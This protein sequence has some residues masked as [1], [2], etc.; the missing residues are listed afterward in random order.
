MRKPR[1]LLSCLLS[2]LLMHQAIAQ[3][4]TITGT[5]RDEQQKPLQGASVAPAGSTAGTTTNA[6]GNFS[7]S[8][9][10]SVTRLVIT[11]IGFTT[12]EVDISN[13][14]IV[15]ITLVP[16]TSESL[17]DVV[18][19]G[20]GTARRKDLTGSVSSISEKDLTRGA[21]T[22]PLQQIAGRA[23]G[24]NVNQIGS[25]PGSRPNVRIRGITSLSGGNDPL[26]VVDGVQGNLDLLNQVPPNEI[27]SVDILKD[28]SAT[29][30]YGSRGAP[31][32][33]IVT[34]KKSKTG[35]TA[36]EYN[37][38]ASADMLANKLD[39]LNA[40]EWG[41][42]ATEWGVPASAN[43]GANNDWYDLLTRTGYTQNHTVSFG[44]G[45]NS[46]SYRAS[47]NAI[48]QEG[49]VIKSGF[50]NYN[51][52]IQATQK[53]LDDKLTL[54]VNLNSGITN[55]LGSPGGLGR[56]AFRSNLITAAYISRPTDPIYNPNGTFF[57]DPDVFEYLN[58]YAVA[59]TMANEGKTNY[60]LTTLRGDLQ[61]LRGLTASWFGSWRK[62]DNN[63]GTYLPA[64][65][66]DANAIRQNGVANINN[67]RTDEKLMNTSL[68]YN[69]RKGD[70][71]LGLLAL[72]EW[73]KQDYQGNFTQAKGF[74][75]DLASFNA[76]QF[77][78][79]SRVTAGDMTSYRND[80]TTISFLGRVN[81]SYLDRYLVT[82]SIRRDGSSVLGD[83][84]K[85]GNFQSV[86]VAWNMAEEPFMKGQNIFNSL[87][88]KAG[89]GVTGNVQGL[90]P[91]NS[92][93]LVG[94][95][96]TVYFGGSQITNFIISQN[97]NPDLTWETKKMTNLG[98]EFSMLQGRI[99]GTIEAYTSETSNLLFNYTVPQPPYPFNSVFANV[100]KL[101]NDGID[102]SLSY[103][104]IESADLSL[105]LA[106]N[107]S[108]MKNKVLELSGS[109]KG[110]PLITDYVGWGNN[111]YLIKGEPIGVFNIFQHTGKNAS[112]GETVRDLDESGNID[113]AAR[114]KDRVIMGNSL[115]KYTFAFA[116]T[117][118]YKR[119]DISMLWR[120]SGGNKIYNGLK[121]SLSLYENIGK[122]N[123]LVSA[124][125]HGIFTS[126]YQ[127]DLFLENGAY[128]RFDNVSIGY[129][130][131]LSNARYISALRVSATG[132][133]IAV[134][135]DYSGLDPEVN[136]NGGNGSGGDG[137]I[138]PR[139]RSFGLG[140]NVIFK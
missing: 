27:E 136:V 44:G 17:N 71:N 43:K 74:I 128:I 65:S 41:Q 113:Q 62:T 6:E 32:V 119:I 81:Y 68:N 2:F 14:T 135:T 133:N 40:A 103:T 34:T 115:P 127:S 88:L 49:T 111:S 73:Q 24:V 118:T 105:T 129:R 101:K 42:Q 53:A 26:V 20:Y 134:F 94:S 12:Q 52:R 109:I 78:D 106:G 114:S 61:V 33:I 139:S 123:L 10:A 19:V 5:V 16:G 85:W 82:A 86:A 98:L 58:P 69:F 116:P 84:N 97:D 35:R 37:G 13:Q 77:G 48:L 18:V 50:R 100:G 90:G 124:E 8:V 125:E 110:I 4:K 45:A 66:T 75:N 56:A 93:R 11:N 36:L 96:G 46:F 39:M 83:N 21:I 7:L 95:S 60:F 92:I 63:T 107:F 59:Q 72:Y 28:A 67:N 137:G 91:Q 79:L 22:N 131:N 23:P 31:G 3:T 104:V 117:F 102:V 89:Y 9:S 121:R 122:S 126:Q 1:L 55:T 25:E 64:A 99:S 15:T 54:T 51:G 30:I 108:L 80:R 132:N 138:Y 47:L 76:L 70:H 130:F 112:N 29:A 120:G 140:V 57:N 38:F 87:K